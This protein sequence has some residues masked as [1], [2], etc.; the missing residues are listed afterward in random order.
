MGPKNKRN[1]YKLEYEIVSFLFIL[2]N[3][4]QLHYKICL[5]HFIWQQYTIFLL[6]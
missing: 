1:Q 5:K 3:A 2:V 4:H 6:I